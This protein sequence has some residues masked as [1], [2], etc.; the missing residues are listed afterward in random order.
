MS[1][2]N[3]RAPFDTPWAIDEYSLTLEEI[4][5]WRKHR[6]TGALPSECSKLVKREIE[7]AIAAGHRRR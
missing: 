3:R 1:D 5:S 2:E 7:D 4:A 6:S